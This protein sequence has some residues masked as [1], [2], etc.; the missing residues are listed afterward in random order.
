MTPDASLT[1][2]L[3][4]V[5]A[6]MS[7]LLLSAETVNTALKLITSVTAQT[8]PRTAGAGITLIDDQG[9][10]ITAAATD[11]VVERVDRLQYRLG[12]GPFLTA[13]QDRVL[14]RMDDLTRD[15][16]WPDWARHA[17]EVGLR[18][19]LS[20]PLVAGGAS[21]GAFKVYATHPNAYAK[22]EE[23]LL[24]LFAAQAAMLLANMRTAEQSERVAEQLKDSLRGREVLALAKGVI[25][26]RDGVDERTAFLT[27]ADMAKQQEMTLR[28]AAEQVTRST[29]RR[30]R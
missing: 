27:L 1:E 21:L 8:F 16:R 23:H 25:M 5:F 15:E 18:S 13:W 24:T 28:Q 19:A 17:G 6:H 22:R 4:A 2:E 9:L 20:A 10:P 14:V 30:R 29:V 7:G 12:S 3:A 26:A 11:T